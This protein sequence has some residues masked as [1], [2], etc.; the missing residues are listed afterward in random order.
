MSFRDF[1]R[2][3]TRL[4]ICNL[5]PDALQSRKFR[6][7]NAQLYDGT[8]RRGS[9]AGGCRN[10]PGKRRRRRGGSASNP[11]VLASFHTSLAVPQPLSGSTRSSRC[12]WRRWTTTR[13]RAAGAS[14]AAAS[15]WR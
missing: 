14:P 11:P 9:T 3:F 15:C 1:L 10:Y 2:E 5:T 4:E 12:S 7:W 8:W 13:T 6:K